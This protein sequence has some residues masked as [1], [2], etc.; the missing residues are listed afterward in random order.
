MDRGQ[1]LRRFDRPTLVHVITLSQDQVFPI[2]VITTRFKFVWY[3]RES[4][5][6]NIEW[7]NEE[8]YSNSIPCFNVFGKKSLNYWKIASNLQLL[9]DIYSPLVLLILRPTTEAMRTRRRRE[10]RKWGRGAKIIPTDDTKGGFALKRISGKRS[11]GF[12]SNLFD[13]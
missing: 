2:D 6:I 3:M 7:N 8:R 1:M 13:G 9:K 12:R 5:Q 10:E 4:N 11:R